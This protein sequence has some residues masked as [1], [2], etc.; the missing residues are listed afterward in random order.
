VL[1]RNREP[2]RAAGL[3]RPVDIR[4]TV[5]L[6]VLLALAPK[7]TAAQETEGWRFALGLA[8]VA[9]SQDVSGS[10]VSDVRPPIDGNQTFLEGIPELTGEVAS[11]RLRWLPTA[12]RVFAHAGLQGWFF[13]DR[14]RTIA[15]EGDFGR[16]VPGTSN[17]PATVSGQGSYL[18]MNITQG[19][20]TGLG[21][22]FDVPFEPFPF[23]VK[24]SVDYYSEKIK[25][26][27]AAQA[28]EILVPGVFFPPPA[29]LPVVGALLVEGSSRETAHSVGPRLGFETEVGGVGP[30]GVDVFADVGVYWLV[31]DKSF[32]VDAQ[33]TGGTGHFEVDLQDPIVR[34][35]T[36]F[37]ISLDSR[38]LR[39]PA[40]QPE[41]AK[42]D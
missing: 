33:G 32:A 34:G 25:I 21:F 3:G 19:W 2:T 37:R 14:T 24:P 35:G 12:P 31:G 11:P 13:F 20:Y 42:S 29:I 8:G 18:D 16:L 27:A 36:G 9:Q 38:R 23:R 26:E 5:L 30:F 15:S 39:A 22:T 17:D 28:A 7:S 41:P 4:W 40:P 1:D 10:G 6:G